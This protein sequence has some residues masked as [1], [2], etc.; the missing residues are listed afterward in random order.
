M[1]RGCLVWTPTPPLSG[2]RTPR[3][4][5][6]RV[7]VCVTLLAESGGLASR[8]RCGAIHLF[9]SPVLLRSLFS[10]PPPGWGG[11]PIIFRFCAPRSS[12]AFLVFGLRLPALG[13]LPPPL[14]F[15]SVPPP[16]FFPLCAP[17]VPGVPYFRARGALG[18]GVFLSPPPFFF[19]CFSSLL[20]FLLP[21]LFFF[22][23]SF[24]FVRPRCLLRSM[25]SGLGCLGPWRLLVSP[26]PPFFFFLYC[27]PLV[28]FF[29]PPR[30][31]FFLRPRCLW[32]S[33]FSGPGCL[34]PWR[35]VVVPAP[36]PLLL[37]PS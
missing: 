18:L 35:V 21:W 27:S 11:P 31:L 37:F 32:R 24:L 19:S 4:C 29:L 9:L 2:R 3:P 25:F 7:C 36:P 1:H 12:P 33:V 30:F 17:V 5:P 23:C 8:A 16:F 6:M 20:L 15:F 13:V 10:W 34:G 14:F 26:P 28:L 22:V